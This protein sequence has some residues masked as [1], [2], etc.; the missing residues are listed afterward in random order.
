MVD[1]LVPHLAKEARLVLVCYTVPSRDRFLVGRSL[2]HV[3]A[4]EVGAAKLEKD[5]MSVRAPILYRGNEN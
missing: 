3:Q 1:I 2:L 4:V 5:K